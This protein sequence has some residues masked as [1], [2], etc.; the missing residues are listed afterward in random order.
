MQDT[1]RRH[2]EQQTLNARK[3]RTGDDTVVDSVVKQEASDTIEVVGGKGLPLASRNTDRAI[4]ITQGQKDKKGKGKGKGKRRNSVRSAHV[5][6]VWE[7]QLE[8]SLGRHM[9]AQGEETAEITGEIT[10]TEKG[11][12]PTQHEAKCLFCH[13]PLLL[14]AKDGIL[15][16]EKPETSVVVATPAGST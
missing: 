7:G 14:E 12:G 3:E 9:D 10:I 4:S 6:E 16:D 15:L 1:I 8:G 11:G 13:E 5:P 2:W